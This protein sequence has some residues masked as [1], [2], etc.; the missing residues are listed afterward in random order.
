MKLRNLCLLALCGFFAPAPPDNEHHYLYVA[1]PGIRNY[2]EHGGV[3]VLV[4]DMNQGYKFVRRIP[5]QAV[6]W[7]G[8]LSLIRGL[9]FTSGGA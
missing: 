8:G 5:S 4:F 7:Q 3:G 2:V 6:L 9:R 1:E